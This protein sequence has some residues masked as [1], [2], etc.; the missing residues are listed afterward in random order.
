M[1]DHD[2]IFR[3]FRAGDITP[4]YREMYSGMMMYAIKI[5]GAE[6]AHSAE[7]CVQ[8]AVITTFLRRREFDE[9]VRWRNFL[10]GCIRYHEVGIIRK[11]IRR[12]ELLENVD[13]EEVVADNS[14]SLIEHEIYEMVFSAIENLPEHYRHLFDLSFSQGLKNSEV[15]EQ[16]KIAEITVK[17]HKAKM[18]SMLRSRLGGLLD[19]KAILL[20]LN[21]ELFI[22]N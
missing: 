14:R 5:L 13:F 10:L 11:S 20:L 22:N 9:T 12:K 18:I 2:H 17:K 16:L 7:D 15:A 21:T 6:Y 4:F 1:I 8:D 19:E 3:C